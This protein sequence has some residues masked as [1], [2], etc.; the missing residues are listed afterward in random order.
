M[1]SAKCNV[2][3]A[4]V[5]LTPIFALIKTWPWY[6]LQL[7]IRMLC[8]SVDFIIYYIVEEEE[9][10]EVEKDE[11]EKEAGAGFV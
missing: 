6:I 9:D 7:Y 11:E 10:V 2:V 1:Q 8:N 3:F 4:P 5:S